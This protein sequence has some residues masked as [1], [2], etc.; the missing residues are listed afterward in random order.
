MDDTQETSGAGGSGTEPERKAR[1]SHRKSR[2]GCTKCKERRIKC[3]ELKPKCSRCNK[4]NLTCQ[5]PK[6][7]PEGVLGSDESWLLIDEQIDP[8]LLQLDSSA[9]SPVSPDSSCHSSAAAGSP[10]PSTSNGP[11][12]QSLMLLPA[13]G[14]RFDSPLRSPVAQALP[15][16]EYDLFKHYLEHTSKDMTVDE[17]DQYT[18]QIG[19]PNLACQSKPL[20][21]SVLALAAACKCSDI[22]A[23]PY[24]SHQD[25][26]QVIE[27]VS[28][29]HD[30]HMESLRE[31]QATLTEARQYDN[32]LAN[33][34][35]MGMYGS[36]SHSVRIWLVKTASLDDPPLDHLIPRHSQWITFYRAVDLAY[37][38]LLHDTPHVDD[39]MRLSPSRSL[40][41][42]ALTGN[43][44][45]Q[46]RYEYKVLS[47]VDLPR[48]SPISHVLSPILAA[49]VGS[50]L[51]RLREKG[52]EIAV[53]VQAS[54]DGVMG[55][56]YQGNHY[57][58][59]PNNLPTAHGN[60]DVQ[61]CITAL[62]VFSSVVTATFPVEGSSAA[63]AAAHR[64]S[65]AAD[66]ESIDPLGRLAEVSP[67]LRTFTARATFM[68]PSRV[69]RRLIVSFI[70]KVPTRYLS[71]VE[72]MLGI[73][74]NQNAPGENDDVEMKW[75]GSWT[76]SI[77]PEPSLAHQ[78]AIDIF[79]HW[80]VLVILLDNVW[81]I[82]GI[83]AW[84]LGRIVSIRKDER[85]ANC[86]WNVDQDW[87][88]E[89]MFEVNRQLEKHRTDN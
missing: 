16:V 30:Y 85:W 2:Y 51:A 15:P 69:P 13:Q 31:I 18:L 25:R 40:M 20:M 82:G 75:G 84:E 64:N 49:T 35:M 56:H 59:D 68:L 7:Q 57:Q 80:L 44:N 67:W 60:S 79:A 5:Y 50:A 70:H 9:R 32:V 71:M 55:N 88:P 11:S 73:I 23:Q 8:L 45:A 1:R 89:S 48:T 54:E 17:G 66:L 43:T 63:T 77:R 53:I 38:G 34:I 37:I 29:G 61:A 86:L 26:S 46:M 41:D 3:D 87:W 47:R 52:S 28:L 65:F 10:L 27:L 62:A 78:L 81:W 24:V 4:M 22:I 58:G 36:A 76:S 12:S 6:R 33:A 42:P 74:R 72:E 21:R 19:I 14:R 39:T 83:G